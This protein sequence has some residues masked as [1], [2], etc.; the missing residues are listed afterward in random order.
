MKLIDRIKNRIV[1]PL[2]ARLIQSA[3]EIW[4]D[5]PFGR[6]L[7]ADRQGYLALWEEAKARPFP[8]IDAFEKDQGF[9]IDKD[10]LD[11][12][13]LI[14]QIVV[15]NSKLNYCHGRVLY[16]VLRRWLD[17]TPE[18]LD[19]LILETGTARGFSALCMAKAF[20]DA[21]RPGRIITMDVLPH[22]TAFLWNCIADTEGPRSRRDLLEDYADLS[23][24]IVFL[25]GDTRRQIGKLGL[26]RV[27]FAYLDAQHTYQ[28]VMAEAEVVIARQQPGDVIVF[29]DVTESIFPGVVQ[30]VTEIATNRGYRAQSLKSENERGYAVLTRVE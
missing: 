20:A 3:D 12:L 28:D 30:A 17:E 27:P 7:K 23:D 8:E 13:A 9:A 4:Y 16:A 15:K 22:D 14:T 1:S 19:P 25:Q 21:G 2:S 26:G 24:R 5:A 29:D 11:N 10:W 18:P 6:E